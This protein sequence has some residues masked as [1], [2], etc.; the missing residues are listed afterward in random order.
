MSITTASPKC[1]LNRMPL[2]PALRLAGRQFVAVRRVGR[3]DVNVERTERFRARVKD[4]VRLP[5]PDQEERALP[6]FDAVSC[7]DRHSLAGDDVEP[8]IGTAVAVVG[9]ALRRP[10]RKRHLGGLGVFVT[11]HDAEAITEP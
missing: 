2:E 3:W 1:R 5:A 4:L 11:E 7:D 6:E 9:A 8:L 10:R